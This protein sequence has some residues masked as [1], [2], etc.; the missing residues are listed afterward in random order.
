MSSKTGVNT[1]KVFEQLYDTAL[2]MKGYRLVNKTEY[3]S[4][5]APSISG[6]KHLPDRVVETPDLRWLILSKKWQE[7]AGTAEQKVPFEIIK[8]IDALIK[9][10]GKFH[11]AYLIL[12]GE[13]WSSKLKD[14]YLNG[15]LNMYIN[16]HDL[17][18]VVS[19]D[20]FLSLVNRQQL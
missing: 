17:V 9:S 11:Y 8:L 4:F 15:G 19:S 16:G 5:L 12:G 18:K 2:Q 7:T 3:E 1:G 20:R 13:G 14:V 6:G 10:R